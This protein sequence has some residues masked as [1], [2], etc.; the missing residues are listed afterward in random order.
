MT[1][2]ETSTLFSD[3]PLILK[4]GDSEFGLVGF[5]SPLSDNVKSVLSK[6]GIAIN[7]RESVELRFAKQIEFCH[8]YKCKFQHLGHWANLKEI[9][10]SL[11]QRAAIKNPNL[12]CHSLAEIESDWTHR[13]NFKRAKKPL[14]CFESY[15]GPCWAVLWEYYPTLAR[16]GVYIG[17]DSKGFGGYVCFYDLPEFKIL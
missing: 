2:I 9:D 10:E 1:E 8:W 11:I 13:F 3:N 5:Q 12:I 6:Q 16:I 4:V 7:I 17:R 15:E 14:V